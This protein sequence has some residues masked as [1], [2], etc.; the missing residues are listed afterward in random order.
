MA[1][2]ETE[3]GDDRKYGVLQKDVGLFT[4]A[5]T[6]I[7]IGKSGTKKKKKFTAGQTKRQLFYHFEVYIN[8]F[9]AN[10]NDWVSLMKTSF[11]ESRETFVTF[12]TVTQVAGKKPKR[13][14]GKSPAKAKQ[15]KSKAKV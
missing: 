14:L 9:C 8:N 5:N 15:V 6:I 7:I 11:T 12:M 4:L 10:S 2:H 1:V 13:V 3:S